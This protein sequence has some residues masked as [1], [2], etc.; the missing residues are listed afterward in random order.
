DTLE[1]T[2]EEARRVIRTEAGAVAALESRIG[3]GFAGAVDALLA[4]R[5][6]VV[7]SAIGKSGIIAR[8][9]AATLTSTGTPAFFLHPVEALHGDLGMVGPGDIAILI[10]KSGESDELR[11]LLEYFSRTGV[12]VVAMTGSTQSSLGRDAT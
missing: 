8:K 5:G 3:A 4:C 11:A 12:Q 10:S 9:V 6:R 2:L 7:V 1:E